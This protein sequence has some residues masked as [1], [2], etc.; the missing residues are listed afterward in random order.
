MRGTPNNA[1][2][3][4]P[5][6]FASSAWGATFTRNIGRFTTR[7]T[8]TAGDFRAKAIAGTHTALLAIDRAEPRRQGLLGF[9][10]KREVGDGG[11]AK[12][13]AW[14]KVFKSVIPAPQVGAIYTS[15]KFPIQSFLWGDYTAKPD[16]AYKFS[17]VPMYGT[18]A[19]L[20]PR[21]AVEISVRTE[22]EFDQGHG[23][24]FNRGA[25]ASQAFAR[26]FQ[27]KAPANPDDP[28]DPETAW[29]SRGLLEACLA[30]I[31][32]TPKGDGLR[33]AAYDFT[34]APILNA[35]KSA[36]DRGVYLKIVYHDTTMAAGSEKNANEDAMRKA[37][38]PIDDQ[39]ITF[40][41]S[42][43][44]IPHNK[45]IVRITGGAPKQVWTG[46]TNFTDSGFLGQSN[47][48]HLVVDD[49]TAKNYLDFWTVLEDDPERAVA[50][51]GAIGLSP[52][53]PSLVAKNS[54]SRVFSPRQTANM[55]T[56]YGDRMLDATSSV[57]FTAAFGVS[58]ELIGPLA[59][60]RDFLRFL[61]MERPPAGEAKAQLTADRD[62]IISSGAVLNDMYTVQNGK[63]VAKGKI[64]EFDLEKWHF[65]KEA[66]YRK[67]G[68]IFYIHTKF[69]LIDALS[70]DPLACS[71]SANF[72]AN[73]LQQNDENMLL[74]RGNTR[75]ADIYMTEF[76]RIFRHFY[77]RDIANQLAKDGKGADDAFLD[78]TSAWTDSYFKPNAFKTKPREM[79]FAT[80]AKK[81]S[82]NAANDAA[83]PPEVAKPARKASAAKKKP[84][85]KK[86]SAKKKTSATKKRKTT[87]K[88][89]L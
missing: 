38:L 23:V 70:D 18:P 20:Q 3:P 48:G 45:F 46:S 65:E 56:W 32:G 84:V 53:P 52:N 69:L 72:S 37:S 33:V 49:G 5:A 81:W 62:L 22:K 6:R 73:S 14:L 76:D 34:Y 55:L 82:D 9:A 50:R 63:A 86:K 64:A 29:L 17:I 35:L 7:A 61:L 67:Q 54:I 59:K 15:D 80:P 21:P 75:V 41:R 11:D 40:R 1:A 28:K 44:P 27:N 19:A 83:L 71:G 26:E 42:R 24:W 66:L 8:A 30:F 74:I 60:E 43:T 36:L 78:E 25:I 58:K 13:L 57:M 10:I 88:K 68:N 4:A 85:A 39:K 2:I 77:F 87:P 89:R 12:W 79:F 51:A 31:N 16:T 47:V